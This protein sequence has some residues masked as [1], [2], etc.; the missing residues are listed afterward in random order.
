VPKLSPPQALLSLGIALACAIPVVW[1]GQT[2][3]PER[4][5]GHATV[6]SLPSHSPSPSLQRLARGVTVRLLLANT[7][8]SGVIIGRK[9]QTY[10]VLTCRHVV[11]DSKGVLAP[12]LSILT[13]DGK[14]YPVRLHAAIRSTTGQANDPANSANS[15]DL[16][17]LEF[18]S[19]ATYRVAPHGKAPR[20]GQPVFASGFPNFNQAS[21]STYNQGNQAFQFTTG[22][23]A[24]TLERPLEGGYRLG[25]SN[26]VEL[27][28]SGGPLFN[29]VGELVGINGRAKY[30]VQGSSAYTFSDG[31][32]PNPTLA[33][34]LETL[35]WAIP[36]TSV[37]PQYFEQAK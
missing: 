1:Y 36:I 21:E 24:L 20:P 31:S 16:V 17:V 15:L 4:L 29:Q 10:R 13:V 2:L 37:P 7:A 12:G 28:M 22:Q 11:M 3:I 27:G 14:R 30:P 32:Q 9:G 6:N 18:D 34:K 25:T 26:D 33:A 5:T 8:G 23:F 19:P 35:S